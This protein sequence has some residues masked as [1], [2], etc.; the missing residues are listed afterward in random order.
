MI[1]FFVLVIDFY[2]LIRIAIA[3]IFNP[4][5]HLV[6][7]IGMPRKEAK[8]ETQIHPVIAKVKLRKWYI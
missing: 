8:A 6:I 7:L 4:I 5:A 3:Q 1:L 2:F